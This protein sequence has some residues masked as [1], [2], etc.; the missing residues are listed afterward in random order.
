[1]AFAGIDPGELVDR[2]NHGLHATDVGEFDTL[3]DVAKREAE[4]AIAA[5]EEIEGVGVAIEGAAARYRKRA[6]WK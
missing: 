1:M 2:T 6:R 4:V 3:N 5:R